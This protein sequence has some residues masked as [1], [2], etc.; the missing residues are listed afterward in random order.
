VSGGALTA[1]ASV[2]PPWTPRRPA[3]TEL[4]DAGLLPEEVIVTAAGSAYFDLVAAE[5]GGA[6]LPGHQLRIILR[7]G[8]YVSDDNGMYQVKTP[9]TRIPGALDAALE[10][11]AQVTSVPERGQA[12]AG[13]GNVRRLTTPGCPCRFG[14]ATATAR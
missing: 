9:F 1:F 5:L 13:M 8:A 7:S 10:I 3:V 2:M 6:W 14:Y 12:L 4:A 11:W